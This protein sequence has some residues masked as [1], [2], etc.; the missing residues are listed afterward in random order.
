MSFAV[1]LALAGLLAGT[2]HW[3]WAFGGHALVLM[4]LGI[5]AIGLPG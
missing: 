4:V 3:R 2:G 5:A 1:P